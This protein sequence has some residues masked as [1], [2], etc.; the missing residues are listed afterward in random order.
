MSGLIKYKRRSVAHH[1]DQ[2]LLP[3]TR[4]F[5]SDITIAMLELLPRRQ[6]FYCARLNQQWRETALKMR[7]REFTCHFRSEDQLQNL[8]QSPFKKHF[9]RIL[10]PDHMVDIDPRSLYDLATQAYHITELEVEVVPE[11]DLPAQFVLPLQLRSLNI[12]LLTYVS[13]SPPESVRSM[14]YVQF[15]SLIHAISRCRQL[16]QLTFEILWTA[17]GKVLSDKGGFDLP[18][19]LMSL[20]RLESLTIYGETPWQPQHVSQFQSLPSIT[21]LNLCQHGG[22]VTMNMIRLMSMDEKCL[23]LK[24]IRIHDKNVKSADDFLPLTRF[25]SLQQLKVT[26]KNHFPSFL[27]SFTH[28]TQLEIDVQYV[29]DNEEN[30]QVDV[31]AVANSL[32]GCVSLTTLIISKSDFTVKH[33]NIIVSKMMKLK[34]LKLS[35]LKKLDS[36]SFL[37]SNA[38]LHSSLHSFTLARCQQ[39]PLS[40]AS[41]I[42]QLKEMRELRLE[43]SFTEPMSEREADEWLRSGILPHLI[44]MEYTW[45]GNREVQAH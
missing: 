27:P 40:D 23:K 42:K 8:Y 2:I 18:S 1:W 11:D 32:A 13:P 14:W 25:I 3:P 36:L 37:Q 20:V 15:E 6:F 17:E 26:Y 41:H 34:S 35:S 12:Y 45:L 44:D 30:P 24:K 5:Y 29:A 38:H 10:D 16:K 19:T 4:Q 9:T 7:S 43:D 31:D 28:L 21:E 33:M 22:G 39:I